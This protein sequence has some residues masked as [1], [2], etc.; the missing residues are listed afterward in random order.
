MRFVYAKIAPFTG[1]RIVNI[2]P[3]HSQRIPQ[4]MVDGFGRDIGYLRISVV[5]RCN[6]RCTYC[7]PNG[8]DFYA[9]AREQLLSFE[10]IVRV[11]RLASQLG[12]HKIRLTG[13]EPLVRKGLVDAVAQIAALP[14]VRDLALSTNG[15]LLKKFAEPLHNAGLHRVNISLDSL[16]PRTFERL[17]GGG[18]LSEVLAGI[19]AAQDA[20]LTPI[21]INTVL[22]RGFNDQEA[23]ALIDFSVREQLELRFIELMPM[24]EGL[25]WKRHYYPFAELLNQAEIID[26]V[27]LSHSHRQGSS[28][29][30]YVPLRHTL[31]RIGLIEPMSNHFCDSCNRLRLMSDGKLRPCLSA[32]HEVDLRAAL[33]EGGNDEKL[34]DLIRL[35][36]ANKQ[37]LSTYHFDSTGMQRSMIAIGG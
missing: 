9:V 10:E 8:D 7:R 26:R 27:D 32:D 13:G 21:R 33:R 29:A 17:T 6:L 1:A 25:D 14:D 2:V 18:R 5:D 3:I 37:K 31:G 20:G 23:A 15:I 19:H 28:S 35:A 16:N 11:A 34:L 36:T 24:C 4:P 12:V 30:R 22:V